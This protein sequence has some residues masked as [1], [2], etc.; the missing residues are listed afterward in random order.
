M[1]QNNQ[2]SEVWQFIKKHPIKIAT[3]II[4]AISLIL[5]LQWKVSSNSDDIAS[6]S[7]NLSIVKAV[8]QDSKVTDAKILVSLENVV[9][10][11]KEM[12][13]DIKELRKSR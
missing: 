3:T 1:N 8:Q 7:L 6:N 10:T 9:D 11:L 2:Q 12:K 4:T 5:T 13:Q